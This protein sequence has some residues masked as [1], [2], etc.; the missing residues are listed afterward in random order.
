MDYELTLLQ[1]S[2]GGLT[3]NPPTGTPVESICMGSNVTC[4]GSPE[5]STFLHH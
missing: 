3:N 5:L 2:S 4:V 1:L